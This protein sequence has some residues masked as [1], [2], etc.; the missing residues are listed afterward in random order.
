MAKRRRMYVQ[1]VEEK[2]MFRLRDEH[3][4]TIKEAWDKLKLFKM[5]R[6]MRKIPLN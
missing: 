4:C 1:S 2:M 6:E 5:Q 3:K